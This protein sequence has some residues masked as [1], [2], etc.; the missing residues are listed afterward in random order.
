[1]NLEDLYHLRWN[2]P[3]NINEHLPV[4]RTLATE[5]EAVVEIGTRDAVSTTGLLAGQPGSLTTWDIEPSSAADALREHAG[6][7]RYDV[8]QG[9]SRYIEIGPCDLLLVDS[10][11][12]REQ[13]AIELTRHATNVRRWILLHDTVTFGQTGEDG[14]QGLLVA[15]WEFLRDFPEWRQV[16]EWRNN[17]GL[18]LLRRHSRNGTAL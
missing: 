10:L 14:G 2:Q 12:T 6:R 7:T 11:H 3:H 16:A 9:D 18:T 5:C 13:L 4:L 1:M 17:N 8:R 15:V